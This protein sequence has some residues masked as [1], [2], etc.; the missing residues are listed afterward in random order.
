MSASTHIHPRAYKACLACRQRKSRCE[1]GVGWKPG[2]ACKRCHRQM[3]ACV[4]PTDRAAVTNRSASSDISRDSQTANATSSAP[5]ADSSRQLSSASWSAAASRES[6]ASIAPPDGLAGPVMRTMISNSDDALEVLFDPV[7]HGSSPTVSSVSTNP[8]PLAQNPQN[9]RAGHRIWNAC[10]FVKQGWLTAGE[11]VFFVDKFFANLQILTPILTDFYGEHENHQSLIS[12]EPLLCCTI[13]GISARHHALPCVG[14][15]MRSFYIHERLWTHI[16][17]LL[18]RVL[19]GQEKNSYGKTRSVGTIEALLLLAEWHPR[20]LSVPPPIDGWDSDLLVHWPEDANHQQNDESNEA[21]DR[22]LE[23]VIIP[24]KRCGHMSWMLIN[25]ALSLSLELELFDENDIP[26]ADAVDVARRL[27]IQTLL[28][29]YTE[30]VALQH[31]RQ[32]TLPQGVIRQV[33]RLITSTV[34]HEVEYSVLKPWLEITKL[35]RLVMETMYPSSAHTA[36]LLHNGRYMNLID[37]FQPML[38]TWED[39]YLHKADLVSDVHGVLLC[40][41]YNSTRLYCYSIGL[42]G[43]IERSAVQHGGHRQGSQSITSQVLDQSDYQLITEVVR[44]SCEVLKAALKLEEQHILQHVPT[45]VMMR[46]IS[47]SIFLMKSLGVGVEASTLNASLE[48]LQKAIGAFRSNAVDEM[49]LGFRYAALLELHLSRLQSSFVPSA[50]P[51]CIP[52]STG[53]QDPTAM[54]HGDVQQVQTW[55]SLP[56]DATFAM[57]EMGEIQGFPNF[58]DGSLDFVWNLEFP[59]QL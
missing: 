29:V 32:T 43:I 28:Y 21:R 30:Q 31:G 50:H 7:Q 46:V 47:G 53:I 44:C 16:Q 20:A 18:L 25:C 49:Q 40:I 35:T 17:H 11:A 9:S 33:P 5:S 27:R 39:N 8:A 12:S 36:Q 58:D 37:H 14:G 57:A 55:F 22:W 1:L 6:A 48:L 3:R 59:D 56:A 26:D 34:D 41:E 23:D 38:K 24:A 54:D 13:L 51:G 2:E 42:Q 4:F 45:R 15:A 52:F 10:R 19:L